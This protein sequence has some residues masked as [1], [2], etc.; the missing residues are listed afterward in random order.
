[1]MM[2]LWLAIGVVLLSILIYFLVFYS[3]VQR[4]SPDINP[5][6]RWVVVTGAASGI[7]KTLCMKLLKNGA[8]VFACDMNQKALEDCYDGLKNV[9]TISMDVSK[10]ADVERAVLIV[11]EH[12]QGERLF[13]LVNNAG[14]G[15]PYALAGIVE[16]G[17][18]EMQK[19]FG[20]NVFGV[21]RCT[22]MFYPLMI[23]EENCGKSPSCILNLAS[24][25]GKIGMPYWGYYSP[26]KF[27]VYSYSDCLRKEFIDKK[28]TSEFVRVSCVEP[29]LTNTPILT[30]HEVQANSKF[31]ERLEKMKPRM[32]WCR[33][34]ICDFQNP[35]YVAQTLYNLLFCSTSPAHLEI[36][37][38]WI[39]RLFWWASHK[40]PFAIGDRVITWFL[41][42]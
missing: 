25:A 4:Y 42:H 20:V 1:M 33:S 29:G 22:R 7:G 13:G 18:E 40:L 16:K 39:F 11:K 12:L 26:T 6:G 5:M 34:K 3:S 24:V 23:S 30:I 37:E 14:I 36:E 27:A 9:I 2:I 17:D 8:R 28:G 31:K 32:E 19:L 38:K 15:I 41:A 10:E 35:D 21:M